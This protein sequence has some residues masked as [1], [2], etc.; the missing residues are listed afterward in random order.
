MVARG[1]LTVQRW[2]LELRDVVKQVHGTMYV[3]GRGGRN[4]MTPSDWGKVGREVRDQYG[5]LHQFS[6]EVAGGNLS[7]AQV[8]ARSRLYVH[9]GVTAHGRGVMGAFGGLSL[10]AQPGEGTACMSRCRCHWDIQESETA[11]EA[12]W[13]LDGG[14]QHCAGCLGRAD[15]YAPYRQEKAA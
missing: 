6:A 11:W 2:E 10:P 1:D 12:T 3:F 9:A 7:P 15:E 5:F 8:A 14:A 13:V 4:A